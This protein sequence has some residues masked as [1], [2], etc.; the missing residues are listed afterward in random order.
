MRKL[1]GCGGIAMALGA[2]ALYVTGLWV[3]PYYG[4]LFVLAILL[5]PFQ[6]KIERPVH[7]DQVEATILSVR[8]IPGKRYYGDV[9]L[10]Y[11]YDR[12]IRQAEVRSGGF[13]F[14]GKVV[15]LGV[16][17]YDSSIIKSEEINRSDYR[18]EKIYD[19]RVEEEGA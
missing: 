7:F 13:P 14:A 5:V 4:I 18:C 11:E 10:Q 19:A 1:F 8:K 17:R 2:F 9:V 12:E 15:P 16:C 6:E 3:V